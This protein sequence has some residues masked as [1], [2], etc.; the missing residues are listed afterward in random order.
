MSNDDTTPDVRSTGVTTD[1]RVPGAEHSEPGDRMTGGRYVISERI[2]KGG[3]GE[4]MSAHD[5]QFGRDIAIKR[6]RAAEPSARQ[7]ERFLREARIQARLDH[8]SIVP[9][10]ELGRDIDGRPFF[11]MKRLSGTTLASLVRDDVAPIQR[12]LRAFV[13]VCLAVELAHTRG[14]IHR[15]LKPENIMLG[16]FGE[17]YVLDWGV[18]KVT[19]I[20]DAFEPSG[21]P[22]LDTATGAI[23]GTRGFMA[24]EQAKGKPIDAR[25]DVFA[26]GCVLFEILTRQPRYAQADALS[27]FDDDDPRPSLRAPEREIPPELD[28]LCVGALAWDREQRIASARQLGDGVQRYLDGDRDLSARRT[29]A[30]EHLISAT[31]AF[32]TGD[33]TLALREAARAIALDPRQQA[34]AELVTRLMVEPP[35]S[36]P[37]EVEAALDE[38][39]V[40]TVRRTVKSIALTNLFYL[41]FIPFMIGRVHPAYTVIL[42]VFVMVKIAVIWGMTRYGSGLRYARL[43]LNLPVIALVVRLT[44]PVMFAPT[45]AAITAVGLMSG[46]FKTARDGIVVGAG[47]SLSVMLPC[48]AEYLG[49]LSPTMEISDGRLAVVAPLLT[50]ETALYIIPLLSTLVFI[51]L[52]IVTSNSLRLAERTSRRQVRLQAWQLAQLVPRA[53]GATSL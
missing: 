19:D 33:R 49:W 23:V 8:P 44:S 2:G 36:V 3:Q 48:I 6:M 35:A 39:S 46:A 45:I 4:V 10:Y 15:D 37:P 5:T 38:D 50:D 27:A 41:V 21:D 29:L 17:T 20:D 1:E 40:E 43:A 18:A 11:A 52:A 16:D 51:F 22:E 53:R 7:I 28:A 26:L 14:V 32:D 30:A 25:A 24:P 31:A 13:D 12:L 47:L 34:A 42:F 9:V